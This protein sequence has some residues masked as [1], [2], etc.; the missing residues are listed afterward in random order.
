MRGI[1]QQ[2]LDEEPGIQ[3]PDTFLFRLRIGGEVYCGGCFGGVIPRKH[4]EVTPWDPIG[5]KHCCN[6]GRVWVDEEEP[7]IVSTVCSCERCA[8]L[9]PSKNKER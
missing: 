6:C 7:V 5:F 1:Y 4:I 2:V 3:V 8:S 9:Q